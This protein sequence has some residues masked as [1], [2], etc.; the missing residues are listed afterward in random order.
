[1]P[2]S[3]P[4]L[5]SIRL[6]FVAE[7]FA[8][9]R[10]FAAVCAQYAISEK[11]GYKWLARFRR[12]GPP[13]LED[14]GHRP[15]TCPHQTPVAQRALLTACR[16]AHPTWGARKLRARLAAD[17]PGLAWP[18]ASTITALLHTEGLIRVRARRRPTGTAASPQGRGVA[19]EPNALW[20]IDY[21]GQFRTRDGRWCYPLTIVDAASRFLLAC[22]AHRTPS[23]TG[24]RDVL[25]ACFRTY[26]MPTMLLSDNGPPFGAPRAPRGLSRLSLWLRQHGVAPRFI[27]PGHPEQNGRHERLHRTL[28]AEATKPPAP[29]LRAQQ[30]RFDTYRIEYNTLRPHEALGLTTPAQVYRPSPHPFPSRPEPLA[31]PAHFHQ[32]RVTPAGLIWWHQEDVYVSQSFAGCTVG[33]D[34]VSSTQHDVYFA[35]YLLGSVDLQHLRFTPLTKRPTSP[36]NPV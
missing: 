17:Y 14:L 29:S 23:T 27:V 25:H 34:P 26:G 24:A 5:M 15:R 30:E 4:D 13:G 18:A 10:P 33:L 1:M 8:Q 11:T 35:E 28:K 3:V 32:R 36:I 12:D 21:K 16:R 20:T 6:E 2:W 19:H 9:R 31:Y 7:A 22:V